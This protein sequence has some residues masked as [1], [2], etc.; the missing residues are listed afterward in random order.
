MNSL[1]NIN[2]NYSVWSLM[3]TVAR[4]TVIIFTENDSQLSVGLS[5]SCCW[6]QLSF[7]E[8][9]TSA[10]CLC[11]QCL[12]FRHRQRSAS[13][14]EI[15]SKEQSWSSVCSLRAQY[16]EHSWRCY[17]AATFA[18]QSAVRQYGRLYLIN[19]KCLPVLLYGLEVCPLTKADMQSLDFCF[20]RILMKLFV[21]NNISIVDK[22]RHFFNF[23]LPSELCKHTATF[24]H[25]LHA[26]CD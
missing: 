23:E 10:S 7:I 8:L 11:L 9:R 25:K 24:L 6:S 14:I 22:C 4:N 15:L 20:N 1:S 5:S 16:L 18:R 2:N 17:L 12:L 26:R 3:I 19:S 21:T 13:V